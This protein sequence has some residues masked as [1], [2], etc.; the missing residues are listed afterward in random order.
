[1]ADTPHRALLPAGLRDVLPPDA[2]FEARVIED[3]LGCFAAHGYERVKPPLIEFEDTLFAG[4]GA[5]MAEQTFRLMDPVSQRMMGVRPDITPQIARIAAFR[6]A[7]A[8]RPLRLSYSGQ[9]LRVRGT[10]L[11]PERQFSQA[12]LELIGSAAPAADAEVVMLAVEALTR[13]GVR[14]LS[15]DLNLPRL[16][17]TLCAGA[18]LPAAATRRIKVALDRK[19]AAAVAAHG[20]PLAALFGRLL[21]AAG[22]AARALA[23]L[24]ASELPEAARRDAEHLAETVALIAGRA[25]ALTL[26]VDPIEFRGFEYHGALAFTFF[27]LST[28]GELG[29]GGRYTIGDG[30]EEAATGLSL[31]MDGVLRAIPAAPARR[32]LYVPL[33]APAE[34]AVRLRA[35]GWVTV[36]GLDDEGQGAETILAEARRLKCSHA[37]IAGGVR[38]VGRAKGDG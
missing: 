37:L 17:G 8:P 4:P 21:A 19:D 28:R 26:T 31:F 7:K 10:Q 3:L 16:V 35:E 38:A 22:P 9:V 34:A 11:Q 36:G 33:D 2:A 15:V 30:A 5:A 32:R 12:G 23:E 18:G 24:R 1:M 6:L 13:A 14:D 27:S 29:R 20:G 25:P